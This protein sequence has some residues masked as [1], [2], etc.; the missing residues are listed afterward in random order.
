MRLDDRRPHGRRRRRDALIGGRGPGT[1][2]REIRDVRFALFLHNRL[3]FERTPNQR[4]VAD[5]DDQ[6]I[7]HRG[8]PRDQRRSLFVSEARSQLVRPAEHDDG[9]RLIGAAS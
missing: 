5:T 4:F 2:A 6:S 7:M 9:L 8:P 3:L 1:L